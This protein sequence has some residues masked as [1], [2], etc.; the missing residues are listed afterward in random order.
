VLNADQLFTLAGAT[1]LP[2]WLLLV[3]A[4]KWKWTQRLCATIIPLLLA[5]L[6]AGLLVSQFGK[7]AGG[8]RSLNEVKALFDNRL[9]L[10]AGWVHYLAFDLFI[11][12]WEV[13]DA[14]KLGIP[15]YGVIPCLA[16]TFVIGPVGFALYCILRVG[17]RKKWDPA[18]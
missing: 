8:F 4:P 2:A 1:V 17:I 7:T 16:T 12:S 11:G 6:Y 15:H 9:M 18:A 14:R 10:L 13:R 5:F 3:F